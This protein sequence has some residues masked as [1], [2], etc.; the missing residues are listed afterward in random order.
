SLRLAQRGRPLLGLTMAI[1]ISHG[2][3]DDL[4]N[5]RVTRVVNLLAK[6]ISLLL[7]SE[8]RLDLVGQHQRGIVILALHIL[9]N[10]PPQRIALA[11]AK[12]NSLGSFAD[13]LLLADLIE[14]HGNVLNPLIHRP[15]ML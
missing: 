10:G 5:L 8:H 12:R 4:A 3:S 1:D 7:V 6:P 14:Q 11:L 9:A 2:F 13:E 15:K